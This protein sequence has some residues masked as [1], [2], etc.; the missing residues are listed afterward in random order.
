M[1][2]SEHNAPVAPNHPDADHLREAVASSDLIPL[3]VALYLRLDDS[4]FMDKRFTPD[5]VSYALGIRPSGGLE[6]ELI[7]EARELAVQGLMRVASEN[8]ADLASPDEAT[9]RSILTFLTGEDSDDYL[10]LI[11]RELSLNGDVESAARI[12]ESVQQQ[13]TNQKVVSQVAIIGTGISGLIASIRLTQA[14]IPFTVFEKN[15]GIGGTWYEN[16]YPGSR[17]DTSNFGYSFSFKQHNWKHYYST[18]GEIEEYLNATAKDYNLLPHI[19]FSTEVESLEWDGAA[20]QV[21]A[22]NGGERT[23]ESFSHV[24]TATGQLNRPKIPDF[25]GLENFNGAYWH[26]AQWPADADITGKRVAVVGTGASAFQIVSAIQPDVE[27]LSVFQ[28]SAPWMLPTPGYSSALPAGFSEILEMLPEYG[29][30]LRF[31]QFWIG[32]EGRRRFAVVDPEWKSTLSVSQVNE[33]FRQALIESIQQQFKDRP[34]LF[35]R[36]IPNYPPGGKRILRDDNKWANALQQP[37]VELVTN[38]IESFTEHGIRTSDGV[39]HEFDVVVFCTGFHADRFLSPIK[40]HG[41]DGKDLDDVWQEDA[42]A[43][44]GMHITGFPNLVMLYGPNTNLVVNGSVVF[45]VECAINRVVEILEHQIELGA[46]TF[47]VTE[48]T[49]KKFTEDLDEASRGMAWGDDRTQTWYKGNSG[50]VVSVWPYSMLHYWQAT[51]NVD[52][53]KLVFA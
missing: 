33:E 11:R 16:R 42:E 10:P 35:E 38:E 23:V 15:S 40:I 1:T 22:I 50:R 17:L 49:V 7:A 12:A 24:I 6:D 32:L 48:E 25:P 53:S 43:L 37:N 45:L 36:A 44:L 19:R 52:F 20:W 29:R 46:R 5:L 34:D 27:Q 18:Q 4:S 21:T 2:T 31:Y 47:D 41:I 9:L 3:L 13:P 39:E 8:S 30:V 26:S 14:G 28:R 51:H